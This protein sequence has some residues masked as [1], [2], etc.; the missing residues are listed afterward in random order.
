MLKFQA[1]S[2]AKNH[3]FFGKLDKY[4]KEFTKVVL[5]MGDRNIINNLQSVL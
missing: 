2:L 5:E 1:V 3:N 4:V